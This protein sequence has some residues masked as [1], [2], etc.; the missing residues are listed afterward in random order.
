MIEDQVPLFNGQLFGDVQFPMEA[1]S[2]VAP[3]NPEFLRI[4]AAFA[5]VLHLSGAASFI[6]KF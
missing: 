2:G 3:P 1:D 4:H 5:K 6:E